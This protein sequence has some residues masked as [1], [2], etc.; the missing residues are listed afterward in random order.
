MNNW[1]R[2]LMLC[3]ACQLAATVQA[4][5]VATPLLTQ[6]AASMDEV[7][8]ANVLRTLAR[9]QQEAEKYTHQCAQCAINW[10]VLGRINHELARQSGGLAQL[11]AA[12]AAR[13][14]LTRA[15]HLDVYVADGEALA[16][17]ALLYLE[18]P[19]W[20]LSFG[21]RR[22]A[23]QLIQE[24]LVVGPEH[25]ANHLAAARYYVDSGQTETA[26][27]HL[28]IAVNSAP[29][30]EDPLYFLNLRQASTMLARINS[31]LLDR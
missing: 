7:D 27:Q 29:D 9:L 18:T 16:E 30:N 2:G 12:R 31:K 17:L 6:L 26:R 24:A 22:K 19:P 21:D 15:A 25:V 5:Q 4:Q 3:L 11:R 10:L 23:K 13:D 8:D 20:P 28:L 14:A 1:V